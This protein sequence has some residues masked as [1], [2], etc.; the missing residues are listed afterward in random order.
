[1]TYR[2]ISLFWCLLE[3]KWIFRLNCPLRMPRTREQHHP[4]KLINYSYTQENYK[5]LYGEYSL[6]T[7]LA[8]CALNIALK[9]TFIVLS[10][11]LVFWLQIRPPMHILPKQ[12]IN[13]S[14][15]K[16]KYLLK[17][18]EL[19]VIL[20]ISRSNSGLRTWNSSNKPKS[21]ELTCPILLQN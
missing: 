1:M 15:N 20:R 2:C 19:E 6:L 12:R 18:K 21:H 5:T 3:I 13:Y 8:K 10:F 7:K 9:L 17:P 4:N 14:S 11:F 16:L